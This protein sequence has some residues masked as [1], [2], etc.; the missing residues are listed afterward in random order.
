[1]I[2]DTITQIEARL[3][4]SRSLS[5]TGRRELLELLDT[6]RGEIAELSKTD[7]DQAQSIE[8][9]ALSFAHEA[10]REKRQP[11]LLEHSMGGLSA[12]VA[13]FETTHPSLVQLV[14]RICTTLSN[15]GI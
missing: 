10:T 5:E 9:F 4:N 2:R 12:S 7:A 1:M 14:N 3:N 15:I 8:S 6:L 11:E 13:G